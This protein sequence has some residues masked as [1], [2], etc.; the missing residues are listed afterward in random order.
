MP[1]IRDEIVQK[2]WRGKDPFLASWFGDGEPDLQ[3]W[4]S[5]HHYLTDGFETRRP[6][7][8][9]EVGVWKGGS[10]IHMASRLRELAIDGVV[11]AIDTW[12]GS[13]EHWTENRWFRELG[14]PEQSRGILATFLRNVRDMGL[15]NHIVPLPLDS[16][17]AAQ[18]LHRFNIAPDIVHIDGGHDYAAVYADLKQ[19][20]PV[21]KP[22]GLLI[23]D[24]YRAGNDWP[25][26]K[27]AF[28]D[29]FRPLGLL[30]LENI[31]E[32][33][34]VLKPAM[35][36]R[37]SE[38]L[39]L[40]R[41]TD[42]QVFAWREARRLEMVH[43]K[44]TDGMDVIEQLKGFVHFSGPNW[45]YGL[46][47]VM[48][49]IV[50]KLHFGDRKLSRDEVFDAFGAIR[51]EVIQSIDGFDAHYFQPAPI[52]EFDRFELLPEF[53]NI[54]V[55]FALPPPLNRNMGKS[56]A[57]S[58]A[59]YRARAVDL[60][61]SPLGFQMFRAGEGIYWPAASTRAYARE[62]MDCPSVTVDKCV[63]IAQDAFEGSNFCHFLFDWVPR[64]GHF[65]DAGL[66][67][68]SSCKFLM[69]GA[70]TEFHFHV[71]RALCE[72][73]SL[74]TDQ[75][76]FPQEPQVWH[77]EGPVYFFSDLKEA[78][79]HP[80]NMANRRSIAIIREVASKIWTPKGHIKRV[81]ISR[82]DTPLRRIANE[83]ELFDRLKTFGFVEVRL[84]SLPYL[85]QVELIR[86]A[87]VI[88]A[89][90]GMGLTHI[91]FHDGR[92]LI[93]ELHNPTIGTDSYAFPA[94]ALGFRYRAI[95]GTNLDDAT[96][97]FQIA[98]EDVIKVLLAEGI[99][100]QPITQQPVAGPRGP[101][102]TRVQWGMQS[103]PVSE[104]F[105]IPPAR[106]NGS[107]YRHV[108]DDVALQPD[109]NS[110]WLEA[111]GVVKGT[112]YHCSCDVML[113]SS[114]NGANLALSH[115]GLVSVLTRSADRAIRDRWQTIM[116]QGTAAEDVLAF[117]L[118][119]E[120]QAGAVF[121]SG[122]WRFG[123]GACAD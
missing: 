40:M 107:V 64:V 35:D 100:Q 72:I 87:E 122:G 75:F 68:P 106:P 19:W 114:F 88:I 37:D 71:V 27:R 62:A 78:T 82:G 48:D 45:H 50:G 86:G 25:G 28:D 46:L 63:V 22:G 69:G 89:P 51:P 84:G 96:N 119:C 80:A 8:I 73:Y 49:Q 52:N 43:L 12:L 102:H 54:Y 83:A 24:D 110:G 79:M 99:T 47:D 34:R 4:G 6:S 123:A 38:F 7:I 3:G 16:V 116:I 93:V 9:V 13:W 104:V 111:H 113:P 98:P 101:V 81:Y 11:I 14:L 57:P 118:R 42:A 61:V 15:E 97:N 92:P 5:Q 20:W 60:F 2:L 109:S 58:F 117:A 112:V 56:D 23:G 70:P 120:A 59:A 26:V 17:N 21:L 30:P 41:A 115:S 66:E 95:L 103:T 53:Q 91:V 67:D 31:S 121:Y 55:P 18:V 1:R 29:Y 32:K 85:Q 65:L 44:Q 108:R 77:T 94:H 105:D 76:V 74:N 10:T 36:V 90:H 33:C 39:S